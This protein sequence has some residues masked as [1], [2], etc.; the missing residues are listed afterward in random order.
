MLTSN[1]RGIEVIVLTL[2]SGGATAKAGGGGGHQTKKGK[3]VRFVRLQCEKIHSLKRK[4]P[5]P[6][7][8]ISTFT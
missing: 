6:D 7:G 8:V 3:R 5:K 1:S 4:K 2:M